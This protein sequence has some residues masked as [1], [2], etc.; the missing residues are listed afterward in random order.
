M[1]RLTKNQILLLQKILIQKFG[2]V[3]GVRDENLFK[4][5]IETPFQTFGGQDLYPSLIEKAAR[6]CFEN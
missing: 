2:G 5:A 6:I 1:I 3:H 4:S